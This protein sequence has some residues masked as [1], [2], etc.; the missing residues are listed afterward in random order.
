MQTTE[1]QMD[2]ICEAGTQ[3]SRAMEAK[4]RDRDIREIHTERPSEGCT[5]EASG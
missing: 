2:A 1:R 3:K 5:P 4:E